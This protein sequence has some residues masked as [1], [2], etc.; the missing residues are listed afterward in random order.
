MAISVSVPAGLQRLGGTESAMLAGAGMLIQINLVPGETKPNFAH[1]DDELEELQRQLISDG[2]SPDSAQLI[3]AMVSRLRKQGRFAA[4]AV[5]FG[6]ASGA[7]YE[8]IDTATSTHV[9]HYMLR[10]PGGLVTVMAT[11]PTGKLDTP[12]VESMLHSIAITQD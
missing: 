12:L 3:A 4:S 5:R 10:V 8:L 7:K 1:A 11:S 9:I 2:E 6:D